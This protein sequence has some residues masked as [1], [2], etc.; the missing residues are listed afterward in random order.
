M[1][2]LV[3]IQIGAE[4]PVILQLV[5]GITDQYPQ[6]EIRDNGANLL[7]TLSLSHQASGVY[8]P[9]IGDEYVMPN[10]V[11]IKITY[12]VYS[13]SGHTTESAIYQ[14]DIDVFYLVDP[15]DYKA[16]GFSVPNEYDTELVGIQSEVNG[17]NGEAMRGSDGVPINPLLDDD[18]RLT[19]LDA[20]ISSRADQNPPS[21]NLN[22]YK[23]DVSGI[24]ADVWSATTRT[25]TSFGTLI[26]DI[27]AY[28]TRALSS[29]NDYKADVSGLSTEANAT[30]NKDSIITEVN[31][32]PINPLLT[33]D[34][35]LDNLINLDAAVSDVLAALVVVQADLDN[36]TQYK[37]DISL[38]ALE[39][40]LLVVKGKTDNL[41]DSW[42]DPDA[43]TI[44]ETVLNR[45]TI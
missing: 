14:R 2:G 36:P 15:D 23:A 44:A 3:N 34:A 13:N 37:A 27:W 41:K 28:V 30:T 7:T 4:V 16:T 29:P 11:F 26:T 43:V 9:A 24:P 35:R 39:A 38:L 22:D 32:I 10:E 21:Q 6:A 40:T 1:A 12:I 19:A 20:S 31:E 18:V 8:V 45:V 42:N 17:L 33:N 25:L 5:D